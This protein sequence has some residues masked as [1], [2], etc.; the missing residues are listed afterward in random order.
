[1]LL[2]PQMAIWQEPSGVQGLS[3]ASPSIVLLAVVGCGGRVNLRRGCVL[4]SAFRGV[5]SRVCRPVC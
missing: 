3:T 5:D 1:V 2:D 4:I